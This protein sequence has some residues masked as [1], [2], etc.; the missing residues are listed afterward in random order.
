VSHGCPFVARPVNLVAPLSVRVVSRLSVP[1]AG[2]LALMTLTACTPARVAA[3]TAAAPTRPTQVRVKVGDRIVTV[4]LEDYVVGSALAEISPTGESPA[5]VMKIFQ[6]QSIL[7]RSYAVAHLGRHQSEGFDLC[8]TTHCQL[9]DPSRLKTSRFA[10]DAQVAAAA[11]RGL[12]LWYGQRPAEALFHADCGGHTASP[13]TI[14]GSTPVAYL[15]PLKDAVPTLEHRTWQATMTREALR[16]A[17]NAD[18]RSAVGR[19]LDGIKIQHGDVSGRA[20]EIAL[21]GEHDFVIRGE[22]LRT[23]LNRTLGPKGLQS[24]RFTITRRGS[25]YVF[26]GSGYGHGVGLCQLG[27][28]VRAR[29]GASPADILA[30]YFPN[31][32]IGQ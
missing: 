2:L 1:V 17:L 13:E 22:E 23:I 24:T 31:V 25:T 15:Q 5:T 4:P 19:R 30:Y 3:P 7:A 16:V 11:T 9:Y 8:D 21:T 32:H 14:W 12:L 20:A 10:Q 18:A 28:L 26:D 29:R 6:V 27:A